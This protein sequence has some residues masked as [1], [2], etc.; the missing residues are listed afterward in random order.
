ESAAGVAGGGLDPEVGERAF[1][2][3]ATVSDAI[4]RD[5][6]GEDEI[7]P[8]GE[9]MQFARHGGDDFFGDELNARGEI[10]VAL[11]DVLLGRTG[12]AAEESV[13]LFVRH[14]QALAIVEIGHVH[15]ETA[16]RAQVDEMLA[17]GIGEARLAVRSEAHEFVFAA[18]YLEA[19]VIG[20]GGIE[21]AKR[22]WEF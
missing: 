12:R 11:L 7:F 1:A 13:E 19:A 21:Q 17:N 14:R 2:E 9:A 22:V 20:E 8:A 16:I 15:L 10:H 5:A 6:A 18:A 3:E 4:E